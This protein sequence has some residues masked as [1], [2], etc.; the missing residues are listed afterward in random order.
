M[1]IRKAKMEE[2]DQI[3]DLYQAG[4][5]FMRKTGNLTQWVNGYPSRELLQEDIEKGNLYVAEEGN[6]LEA[7]FAFIPGKDP[8]YAKIEGAWLDDIPY[9]TIHRIVTS[10]RVR[11]LSGQIFAWCAERS[12][13]SLRADTHED[14]APMRHVLEKFGFVYCGVIHLEDGSPRR[15]YQYRR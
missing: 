15:A 5:D 12:G 10:M 13:G 6:G 3:L 8:T 2:M 7:V 1:D 4:R 14:N 11:G 9:W